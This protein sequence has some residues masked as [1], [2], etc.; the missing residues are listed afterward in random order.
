M[1]AATEARN[2]VAHK[3]IAIIVAKW[4]MQEEVLVAFDF[5]GMGFN[6]GSWRI[7]CSRSPDL[8]TDGDFRGDL[9]RALIEAAE[10]R[11]CF[12]IIYHF[13][14]ETLEKNYKNS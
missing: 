13:I 12:Q 14:L 2:P 6:S 7:D 8:C 3:L 10:K 11:K 9:N 4:H 1:I 5:T